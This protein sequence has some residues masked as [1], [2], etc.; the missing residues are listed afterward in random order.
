MLPVA[1]RC[2][3]PETGQSTASAP[4]ASTSAAN[5]RISAASVVD[6]SSQIL[7][8]PMPERTPPRPFH[9]RSRCSRRRQA[10]DDDVAVFGHLPRDFRRRRAPAARNGAAAVLSRS[11]TMSST[12]LRSSVPASLPPAWPSPMNPTFMPRPVVAGHCRADP[13]RYAT[14]GG[15]TWRGRSDD[16][17]GRAAPRKH[18]VDI[19]EVVG[20]HPVAAVLRR[21]PMVEPALEEPALELV[22][23]NVQKD[24]D[25][26]ASQ[27]S[28]DQG[29]SSSSR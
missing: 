17:I 29:S 19:R 8:G 1:A 10:G 27:R 15:R 21:P 3:P 13:L 11:R 6:I 23:R 5:R 28:R 14:A 20:V 25:S 22:A 9:D 18:A 26:R 12:P 7:P 16:E 24:R 2:T 4:A